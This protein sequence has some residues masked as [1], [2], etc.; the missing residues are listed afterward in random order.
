MESLISKFQMEQRMPI[1]EAT[2][3]KEADK[4]KALEKKLK[5]WKVQLKDPTPEK[6]RRLWL[7]LFS[8]DSFTIEGEVTC[9]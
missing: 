5:Q 6:L 7:Y 2:L 3:P 4:F 1:A 8:T 9:P